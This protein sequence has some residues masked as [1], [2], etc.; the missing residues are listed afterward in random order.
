MRAIFV[1]RY[2]IPAYLLITLVL[3]VAVM[4]EAWLAPPV[5]NASRAKFK[6]RLLVVTAWPALVFSTRGRKLIKR[7]VRGL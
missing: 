1:A 5:A 4:V 6:E 7:A 2:L 3:L